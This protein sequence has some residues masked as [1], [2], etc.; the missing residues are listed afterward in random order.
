VPHEIVGPEI[1]KLFTTRKLEKGCTPN[2]KKARLSPLDSNFFQ[3][4]PL[5]STANA[6]ILVAVLEKSLGNAIS[7]RDP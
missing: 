7:S 6:G 5:Q 4:A 2:S 1:Y 3:P